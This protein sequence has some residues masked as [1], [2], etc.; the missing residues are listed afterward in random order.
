MSPTPD[1]RK[2]G[3]FSLISLVMFTSLSAVLFWVAK[4]FGKNVLATM[5]GVSVLGLAAPLG[6]Y[7]VLAMLFW[8]L[9]RKN[10]WVEIAPRI[11]KTFYVLL[12]ILLFS[13]LGLLERGCAF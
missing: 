2:Y 8:P 4:Y 5:V 9:A 3:Q 1:H 11:R 13:A 7:F 10:A 12:M 6:V